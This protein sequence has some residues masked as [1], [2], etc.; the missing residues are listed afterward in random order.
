M[1]ATTG[2]G[3]E[4]LPA[5]LARVYADAQARAGSCD[6]ALVGWQSSWTWGSALILST[7]ALFSQ[8]VK[9]VFIIGA[10]RRLQ[11]LPH[12]SGCGAHFGLV[13]RMTR[14]GTPAAPSASSDTVTKLTPLTV[15]L[16]TPIRATSAR[17]GAPLAADDDEPR[18]VPLTER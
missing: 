4:A 13:A 17:A 14:C 7:C 5:A 18:I 2:A 8:I 15:V 9:L 12:V 6:A 11:H 1:A 10:S 3:A 16:G